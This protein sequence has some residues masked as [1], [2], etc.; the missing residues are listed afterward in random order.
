M[1][2]NN[3]CLRYL[4]WTLVVGH[5]ARGIARLVQIR[6][7]VIKTLLGLPVEITMRKKKSQMNPGLTGRKTSSYKWPIKFKNLVL[8][9]AP[10]YN[11]L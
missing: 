11:G 10:L 8:D 6:V 2:N 3:G 7:F 1:Y 4:H 9:M 5:F